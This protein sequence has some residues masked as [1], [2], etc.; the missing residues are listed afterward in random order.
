MVLLLTGA[1]AARAQNFLIELPA[2]PWPPPAPAVYVSRVVDARSA[3]A[4]I[5]WVQTGLTNTRTQADLKGGAE[6]ALSAFLSR[7]L[8]PAANARAVVLRLRDVQVA[9]ET[10]AQTETG[11]VRLDAEYFVERAG[12]YLPLL[13]TQEQVSYRGLDVTSHHEQLL[14]EALRR[15]IGQVS[16][17]PWDEL[18][19][20]AAPLSADELAR[21]LS[22]QPP[23]RR[24]PI[25]RAPEPVPGV[26]RDFLEFRQ[27]APSLTRSVFVELVP[28]TGKAWAGQ[29]LHLPHYLTVEGSHEELPANWGFSDGRKVYV[30]YRG[31]YYPLDLVGQSYMFSGEAAPDPQTVQGAGVAGA[32]LGGVVGAGVAAG[33]ASLAT[34]GRRVEYALDPATGEV[35]LPAAE[36]DDAVR[37]DTTTVYVFRRLDEGQSRTVSVLVDGREVG[38]LRGQDYVAIPW[39]AGQG[40]ITICAR[41]HEDAC[42]SFRPSFTGGNY[43]LCRLRSTVQPAPVLKPVAAGEGA[44]F[45]K[46][47]RNRAAQ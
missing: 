20:E 39:R 46:R 17:A 15:S 18:L 13:R 43:V 29:F 12:Q 41:H 23:Y 10:T 22:P 30:H 26:Y 34:S 19:A 6:A 45:V 40:D 1:G 5:G 27:N 3:K 25:V 38:T 16:S 33:V 4:G 44:A 36:W 2:A 14:S 42:F 11:T 28:R 21:G 47:M 32:V 24:F 35:T 37:S 9:E 8:P 7:Q 31:L